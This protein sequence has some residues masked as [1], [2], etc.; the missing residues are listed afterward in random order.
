MTVRCKYH[1]PVCISSSSSS[2]ARAALHRSALDDPA[3]AQMP[4]QQPRC[5]SQPPRKLQLGHR[6][7]PWSRCRTAARRR[8]RRRRRRPVRYCKDCTLFQFTLNTWCRAR[9]MAGNAA[10]AAGSGADD[11]AAMT[12]R[13]KAQDRVVLGAGTRPCF[14]L[15]ER[16]ANLLLRLRQLGNI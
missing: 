1:M 14:E 9:A 12:M 7:G 6:P 2:S 11:G 4:P 16:I 3:P 13:W 8:R 15:F 5:S 10:A